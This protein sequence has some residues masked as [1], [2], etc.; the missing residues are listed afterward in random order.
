MA[1]P[2]LKSLMQH[3]EHVSQQ[4][5]LIPN[6]PDVKCNQGILEAINAIRDGFSLMRGAQIELLEKVDK[7]DGKL[8]EL[9]NEMHDADDCSPQPRK[10]V[11]TT[12]SLESVADGENISRKIK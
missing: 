12:K 7:I 1:Q 5:A 6:L 10:R 4:V 11:R 8:K 3:L 9:C 2:D